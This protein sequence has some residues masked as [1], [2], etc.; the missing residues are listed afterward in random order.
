[1][2]PELQLRLDTP[3]YSKRS[4]GMSPRVR[5]FDAPGVNANDNIDIANQLD[6]NSDMSIRYMQFKL[7]QTAGGLLTA[8]NMALFQAMLG[9]VWLTFN[10][11]TSEKAWQTSLSSLFQP[12]TIFADAAS[13][14]NGGNAVD[15]IVK[16]NEPLL[17]KGGENIALYAERNNATDYSSLTLEWILWGIID[18]RKTVE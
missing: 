11:N 7:L 8:A 4:L 2:N 5:F 9:A 17:I 12:A 18:R 13:A 10:K 6:K 14:Y 16:L 1:M 15:C 3:F